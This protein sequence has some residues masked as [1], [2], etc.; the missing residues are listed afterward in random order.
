MLVII[1]SFIKEKDI[2]CQDRVTA[3]AVAYSN[4][5]WVADPNIKWVVGL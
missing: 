1:I 2:K 3:V 5:K 4:M